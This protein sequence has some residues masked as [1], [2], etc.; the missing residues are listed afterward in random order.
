MKQNIGI[1][2]GTR[3]FS[4]EE[5]LKRH[6]I[7]SILRKTFEHH[8]FLPLETPAMENLSVLLGK[9]GEEGDKLLF[10]ILNSGDFLTDVPEEAKND[11]QS[12]LPYIAEKGLRYDLTVPLARYVATHAH[13]LTFPFRRYQI[14]PV[15][16]ADRP[17]KGRYREFYQCD[18]D[19]IGTNSLLEEVNIIQIIN[20]VFEQL[21]INVE[22]KINHRKILWGIAE[23]FNIND[24][25][26]AFTT[27][28]DKLDKIGWEN[29]LQELENSG[30]PLAL[31]NFLKDFTHN[32]SDHLSLLLEKISNLHVQLGVNDIK[33]ILQQSRNIHLTYQPVFDFSLARGLNYYTGCIFEVLA[34]DVQMGSICG[35]GRYDDLTGIFGLEGY[36]GVGISFGAER[37]YDVM[38]QLKLFPE[39]LVKAG[40]ILI[41]QFEDSEI[42]S[43]LQMAKNLRKNGFRVMIYP[44]PHKI[45]KQLAY[46]DKLHFSYVLMQGGDELKNNTITLKCMN[47]GKQ[48]K[49]HE[50]ILSELTPLN[51]SSVFR[52]T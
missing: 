2:R 8:G 18:I 36:S 40:D 9:Y 24:Q 11:Y 5:T 41:L 15:W 35:G 42:S 3:D 22:I 25:F 26:F 29:V 48:L 52:D 20:D 32:G 45:K 33:Y 21:R 37:I 39:N 19:V 16:R 12:L 6:Y 28:L 34:K 46:A 10:R 17:Q 23:Y 30:Y 50:S 1:P 14:Q 31:I 47:T 38:E 44:E 4:P 13:E 27:I 43:L 51:I 49:F 7:F